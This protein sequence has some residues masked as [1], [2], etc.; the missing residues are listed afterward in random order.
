MTTTI[1]R[2]TELSQ[3]YSLKPRV[4]RLWT[5]KNSN[6]WMTRN[7]P[8]GNYPQSFDIAFGEMPTIDGTT[9]RKVRLFPRDLGAFTTALGLLT[10]TDT[11]PLEGVFHPAILKPEIRLAFGVFV[12]DG[13]IVIHT[14]SQTMWTHPGGEARPLGVSQWVTDRPTAHE[15][16]Q[17]LARTCAER[18]VTYVEPEA[19]HP[20]Q[21]ATTDADR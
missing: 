21:G 4:E 6:T 12:H 18:N 11:E 20:H 10:T 7:L 14:E 16:F 5:A 15:V 1:E 3:A 19:P 2:P 9:P 13:Q 8:D 17:L